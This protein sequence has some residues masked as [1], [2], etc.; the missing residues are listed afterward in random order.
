RKPR[1][2]T[3]PGS[4][5]HSS[6]SSADR[7]FWRIRVATST[8]ARVTP[9]ASRRSRRYAP[10]ACI[11]GAPLRPDGLNSGYWGSCLED[12]REKL[13]TMYALSRGRMRQRLATREATGMQRAQ[14]PYLADDYPARGLYTIAQSSL[15]PSLCQF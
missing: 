4:R 10:N 5:Y 12:F 7:Y 14:M 11:A 2:T 8:S 3:S 6:A 15:P 1:P 13:F 9:I